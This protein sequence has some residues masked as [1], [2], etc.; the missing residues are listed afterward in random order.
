MDKDLIE[1]KLYQL[2]D[3]FNEIKINQRDFYATLLKSIHPIYVGNVR[4]CRIL[5]VRSI[6]L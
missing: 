6:F 4:T 5:F 1:D 2:V 3:Q